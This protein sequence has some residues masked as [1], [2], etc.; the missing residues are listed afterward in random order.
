MRSRWLQ[1]ETTSQQLQ[2]FSKH[3]KPVKALKRYKPAGRWLPSTLKSCTQ[4]YKNRRE[5]SDSEVHKYMC[6]HYCWLGFIS[7]SKQKLFLQVTTNPR[8]AL[9]V[10]FPGLT[11]SHAF[12]TPVSLYLSH[13]PLPFTWTA[14][15]PFPSSL[16]K[17]YFILQLSGKKQSHPGSSLEGWE[18][19]A[20]HLLLLV[21]IKSAKC[22]VAWKC[23]VKSFK[24]I[25]L[26]ISSKA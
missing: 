19:W 1:F 2:I 25:A 13:I 23:P 4:L 16:I 12:I 14:E 15:I 5:I 10:Y 21:K 11:S 6:K 26:H 18:A 24:D 8:D 22:W 3:L 9:P 20:T 7:L 17:S